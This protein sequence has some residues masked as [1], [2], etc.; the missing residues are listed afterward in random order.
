M[1]VYFGAGVFGMSFS[2]MSFPQSNFNPSVSSQNTL[3]PSPQ[4]G[5]GSPAVL[6]GSGF[7]QSFFPSP[8]PSFQGVPLS[9]VRMASQF[10]DRL[11][12]DNDSA[13]SFRKAPSRPT[14]CNSTIQI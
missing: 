7:N 5:F 14:C 10:V 12:G 6:A 1:A 4:S 8:T 2:G 13:L 11:I 9:D 3:A